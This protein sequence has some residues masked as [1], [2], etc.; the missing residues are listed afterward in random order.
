[1]KYSENGTQRMPESRKHQELQHAA[2]SDNAKYCPCCGSPLFER[3]LETEQHVRKICSGCGYIFYLNPKVVAGAVPREDSKIWLVRR[4]IDPAMGSWT[5]PGGYVDLG[6]TVPN[7]A[8]RE[9][10]E[11]SRLQI[12]LDG[13]FNVYSYENAGIVLVVYRATVVGGIAG[14]TPESQEVRAF[15]LEDIPW[16]SLAFPSTRDALQDYVQYEQRNPKIP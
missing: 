8:I 4:N 7:A 6:E 1:M 13:L 15:A 2:G 10:F 12:R 14:T 11:E 5:F 3:F 9:A 16:E